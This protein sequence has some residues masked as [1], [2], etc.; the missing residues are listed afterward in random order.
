M[1]PNYKILNLQVLTC[2]GSFVQVGAEIPMDSSEADEENKHADGKTLLFVLERGYLCLHDLPLPKRN[3]N[4][5]ATFHS[6]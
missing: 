1:I 4:T 3:N 2:S 6:P 5:E